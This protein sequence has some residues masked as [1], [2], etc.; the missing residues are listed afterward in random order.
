LVLLGG[1]LFGLIHYQDKYVEQDAARGRRTLSICE[2]QL[3]KL[4]SALSNETYSIVADIEMQARLLL[5]TYGGFLP[6]YGH[7]HAQNIMEAAAQM[8][9]LRSELLAHAISH[10][11]KEVA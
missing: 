11:A 8:E 10:S 2:S 4:T 1:F 7:E 9:R 6:R 3:G 5:E